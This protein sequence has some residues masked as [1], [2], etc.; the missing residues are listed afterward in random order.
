MQKILFPTDFSENSLNAFRYALHLADKLQA[1]IITLHIYDGPEGFYQEYY[2]FLIENYTITEW[3]EFENYKSEVP[4]L[5]AIAEKCHLGHIKLSHMLERGKP[6]TSIVEIAAAEK[7]DYI[8]LGTKGAHGLKE[9]LM[10]SLT[11]KLINESTVPVLAVPAKCFYK[12]LKHIVFLCHYKSTEAEIFKKLLPFAKLFEAQLDVLRVQA[13]HRE[14]EHELVAQWK[15]MFP[16]LGIGFYML[17]SNDYEG[18]VMDF[19]KLNRESLVVMPRHHKKYID[20][21]MSFS[22]SRELAFHST[23]PLLTLPYETEK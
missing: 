15:E 10:G 14:E 23:I 21:I 20:K 7:V 13:H 17:T 3:S 8:V 18:T 16:K 9:A 19:I 12:P 2:D 1:E 4:K 22:L 6:I 5:K 11:E